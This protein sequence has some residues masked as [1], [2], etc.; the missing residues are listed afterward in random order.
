MIFW[1]GIIS[2]ATAESNINSI[3][4]FER[5]GKIYPVQIG[6]AASI[7]ALYL[8][9]LLLFKSKSLYNLIKDFFLN[10]KNYYLISLFFIYLFYLLNFA[11]LIETTGEYWMGLGYAH[12]ISLFLFEK[13]LFREIFIYFVFF[14]SWI[15]I[16]IYIGKNLRD[17]LIIFFFLL[18]ALFLWPLMHEY[19]D[20]IILVM[21][22][23]FFNTKLFINYKNTIF[24][25]FY[26]LAFLITANFYYALF[27]LYPVG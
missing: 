20:P 1:G 26:L 10:K 27:P 9:P 14:I 11:N 7:V 2:V 5:L 22:F 24:L 25:N 6:Y 19:F 23:I 17:F 3:T 13:S 12:K 15:V 18:L 4:T 21:A 8:L 16:L